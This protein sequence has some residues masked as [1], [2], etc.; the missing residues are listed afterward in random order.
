MLLLGSIRA[1]KTNRKIPK[2]KLLVP[3][4]SK[5]KQLYQKQLCYVCKGIAVSYTYSLDLPPADN[6]EFVTSKADINFSKNKFKNKN[7]IC[8]L[9][10]PYWEKLCPR[11][12]RG[13][14]SLALILMQDFGHSFSQYR[15]PGGQITYISLTCCY[16]SLLCVV[17]GWF[18]LLRETRRTKYI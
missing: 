18:L 9:G 10:G 3:F 8:Q 1:S 17:L 7:V 2:N 12:M 15:P 14:Q 16:L 4:W 6:S 13:P 11:A 5:S